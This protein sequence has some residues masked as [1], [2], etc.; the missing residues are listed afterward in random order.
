MCCCGTGMVPSWGSC[1]APP[2]EQSLCQPGGFAAVPPPQAMSSGSLSLHICAALGVYNTKQC[3]DQDLHW[4]S[5]IFKR[6]LFPLFTLL[7]SIKSI[8]ASSS[9][10]LHKAILHPLADLS[11]SF[12][13]LLCLHGSRVFLQHSWFK[14]RRGEIPGQEHLGK[15]LFLV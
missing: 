12:N 10:I 3:H 8:R 7:F 11:A 9:W 5:Y 6:P 2:A 13:N 15:L 14:M 4:R 1:A